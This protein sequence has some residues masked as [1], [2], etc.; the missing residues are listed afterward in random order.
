MGC[1]DSIFKNWPDKSFVQGEKNAAGK[2]REGSLQVKQ[3]STGFISSSDDMI[4]NT[5]SGV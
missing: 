4:F 3:H 2:G 1:L 5:E